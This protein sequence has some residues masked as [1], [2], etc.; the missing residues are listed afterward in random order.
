MSLPSGPDP[1]FI[2]KESEIDEINKIGA[3]TRTMNLPA[4]LGLASESR[5]LDPRAKPSGFGQVFTGPHLL[6]WQVLLLFIQR[7]ESSIQ[8]PLSTKKKDN[9]P[10]VKGP[11]FNQLGVGVLRRLKS[12]L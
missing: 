9:V 1:I 3:I 7:N 11:A 12:L 4:E 6:Y 5:P 2:S 8:W 10:Q